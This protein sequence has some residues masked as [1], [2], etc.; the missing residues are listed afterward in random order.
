MGSEEMAE[1]LRVCTVLGEY[2]EYPSTVP[3]LG[4]SELPVIPAP[5]RHSRSS[6]THV[7]IPTHN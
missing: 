3:V 1:G 6:C 2:P 4:P 5:G 7:H